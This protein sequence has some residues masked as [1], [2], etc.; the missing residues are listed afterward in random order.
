MEHTSKDEI[1]IV[2]KCTLP[3]T[4]YAQVDLIITERAVFEVT[5]QGLVL[6]E[7]N[8]LFSL[9]EIK[10]A[11]GADFTVSANLKDMT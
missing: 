7:I 8:P 9:E 10:S 4:A 11:T 3:L 2:P 6:T 1:K 5:P